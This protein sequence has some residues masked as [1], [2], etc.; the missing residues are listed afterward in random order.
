VVWVTDPEK[1]RDA[2]LHHDYLAPLADYSAG[3]VVVLNQVDRLDP[4]YIGEVLTDLEAALR[5]DGLANVVL[6]PVAAAPPAG[7]P[8]GLDSLVDTL[9]T[10]RELRQVVSDKLMTDLATTARTLASGAGP[11]VEFDARARKAV[12]DAVARLEEK[13]A[14]SAVSDLA[15]FVDQIGTEIGGPSRQVLAQYAADVPAHV[16]RIVSE[17]DPPTRRRRWFRRRPQSSFDTGTAMAKLNSAV[18]RPIRAELARRAV[19][20]ASIADLAVEVESLRDPPPR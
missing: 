8:I 2:R 12:A 6:V 9:E 15:A 11:S 5:A 17:I 1:Y 16:S 13:D 20:V 7:P 10:M 18:I 3:F 19:A 14:T 4:S